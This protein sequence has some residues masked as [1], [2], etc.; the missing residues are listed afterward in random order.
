MTD[1]VV[2][3][4]TCETLEEAERLARHLL[5]LKLA[6]CVNI[7]PGVRSIYRW[8]DKVE[9]ATE[10]MLVIKSRRDVLPR[11]RAE[12]EK[13]HSYEIPEILVLPVVEGSEAYLAWLDREL[14][15]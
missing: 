11:L 9:E 1:K 4:S 8:R 15:G 2:V 5:E 7:L 13:L 10:L 6:A 14:G 12:I 3:L